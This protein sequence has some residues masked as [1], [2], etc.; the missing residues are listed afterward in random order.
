MNTNIFPSYKTICY[1]L[2][3][4]T[5]IV[6]LSIQQVPK[7]TN[8]DHKDELK[9]SP[10]SSVLAEKLEQENIQEVSGDKDEAIKWTNAMLSWQRTS[11]HF[12]PQMNWMNDPNGPLLHMGWYHIFYQYNP[13]DAV[14]G[15]GNLTWGHA[16]SKDLI[17]WFHLPIALSPDKWYDAGGVWSGSATSLPNGEIVML[18]TSRLSNLT[19]LQSVAY[20][21]NISD[22]LLLHWVKYSGNP[23]MFTPEGI[24]HQDFRD[25]STAWLGA[26]GKWRIAVGSMI[27][28]TGMSFVYK[29][30]DFKN[31]DLLDGLL[32]EVPGTGMWECIDFYPVSLTS[33]N[34][35][36][37]SANGVGVKHL[38]K[39][40][41]QKTMKDYYAIGTYDPI[42]DKWT[43]DDPKEDLGNGLLLDSGKYYASKTFYDQNKKR[44]ILWGWV[45]ESDDQSTDLLK[46]WASLQGIPRTVVFDI[47]T[48]TSILQWPV[49]EVE[50]LR[51]ES[52]DFHKLKVEQ[53]SVMPLKIGSASQLDIVATFDVDEEALQS[54]EETDADYSCTSSGGAVTRGILGPFGFLVLA[55][56]SLT[57]LTAVYFYIGK[58]IDGR[59]KTHFC[60]DQSRSSSAS[61]TEKLIYGSD[62]PVLH[63]EKLS[64]RILVDHSIVESFVQGG[65]R[66]ITSRVYPTKAINGAANVYMFNNATG[67]SVTASVKVWQMNSAN[68]KPYPLSGDQL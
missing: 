9:E 46:G 45:G 53:G 39:V 68:L 22:P 38:M 62:V 42:R 11:F 2:L 3:V 47:K 10:L 37:T 56:E 65:R 30:T 29:T 27:N 63:E 50:S 12:Q 26:D 28:K 14:W 49:E 41:L 67:T 21:A 52:Y 60:A 64:M 23:V 25:P 44:R 59:A 55:D 4:S 36:D 5:L 24:G 18:Y 66:V 57:E 19:E 13:D 16:V 8:H 54:I 7:A 40:S 43:P 31:F 51:S 34:G 32:H 48:G 15:W 17:N 61:D 1:I 6:L 20:P 35:L 33:T 58:G